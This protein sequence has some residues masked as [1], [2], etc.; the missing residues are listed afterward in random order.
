VITSEALISG[1]FSEQETKSLA[2]TLTSLRLPAPVRFSFIDN[3][4]QPKN[5]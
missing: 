3:K 4:T 1:R 5:K 2:A